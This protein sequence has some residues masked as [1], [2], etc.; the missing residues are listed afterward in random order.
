MF[1]LLNKS[2][3]NFIFQAFRCIKL[4]IVIV[5]KKENVHFA[6]DRSINNNLKLFK[7][8]AK[9]I[10]EKLKTNWLKWTHSYKNMK[11]LKWILRKK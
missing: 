3:S 1:T 5:L 6:R 11:M 9:K 10:S 7:R 8:S 4:S 2:A